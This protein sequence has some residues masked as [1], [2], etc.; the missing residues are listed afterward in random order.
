MNVRVRA[1]SISASDRN[2]EAAGKSALKNG[3]DAWITPTGRIELD[4]WKKMPTLYF[5]IHFTILHSCA[6]RT[7]PCSIWDVDR[8]NKCSKSKQEPRNEQ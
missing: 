4:F 8:T 2:D 5:D 1:E 6:A 7:G 3:I